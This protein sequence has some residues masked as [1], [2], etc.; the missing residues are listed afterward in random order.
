VTKANPNDK[1]RFDLVIFDCDGVLV[2]SEVISCRAHAETLT[3][4]GYP[5]TERQVL[6]R[7]LGVS[8]R[9]ARLTVEAELG[10]SLPGDFEAQVKQATLKFYEG[11]L[12]AILHIA[13]AIAAIDLPKCVASSG[14]PEKIRH[15]LDCAGLYEA[16]APHIFSATQVARG[17]PAPDLFLF[18]A[19]QMGAAPV[20]C[21]VIEDSVPGVTGARAA[22]MTVLGF[23][24]GSHCL[25]GH[26]EKLRA[27]GA[28]V[29]FDDV[30]Q[31]PGLIRA[32][33]E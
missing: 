16:L 21:V 12:R 23:H 4:H 31:L 8:D 26:A 10:R 5:I 20:R 17:K 2:D 25:P 9:E 19:E 11:D 28:A 24:G 7:F 1:R 13:D 3:R 18:A 29:T 22:G 32:N 30:R 33:S 15:G 27:A 6:E 14:T